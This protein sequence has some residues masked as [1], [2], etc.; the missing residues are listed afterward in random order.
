MLLTLQW[1]THAV[2]LVLAG[3]LLVLVWGRGQRLP[4][5][6]RAGWAVIT[7]CALLY[8]LDNPLIVALSELR[9][10]HPSLANLYYHVYRTTYL[11]NAVAS[12]AAPAIL[13]ALFLERR[14]GRAVAWTVVVAMVAFG[15]ALPGAAAS[16][17]ELL[18]ATRILSF[19]GIAAYL[20]FWGAL[21][22][23]YLSGVDLYLAGF[24]AIDTIFVVL[25]PV[26]EV[27]F[28]LVGQAAAGNY[29]EVLQALQ[30]L[31]TMA[32]VGVVLA[33]WL[34]LGR[35]APVRSFRMAVLRSR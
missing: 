1:S 8:A 32:Q 35:G 18:R 11:L 30:L 25:T 20:S 5:V 13:L 7:A 15:M 33:L 31:T 24:L 28:Q 29:W 3:I 22:L 19:L 34:A 26:Q 9:T 14:R 17:D 6:A 16:W 10:V 23:G 12:Y 21:F 27:F 4:G 2:R